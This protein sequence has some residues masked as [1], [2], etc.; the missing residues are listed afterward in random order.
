ME[1]KHIKFSLNNGY[2]KIILHRLDSKA[3]ALN[4]EMIHELYLASQI[5]AKKEVKVV[6]LSSAR[7]MFCAGGDLLEFTSAK[8]KAGL[9]KS[10]TDTLHRA[11][12][13]FSK[14]DAPLVVLLDGMVAGGGMSLALS[15]DYIISTDKTQIL[16][17]YTAS[18][19]SPDASSTYFLAKHVGL[20]RAKELFLTNRILS[21]EEAY[22]WGIINKIVKPEELQMVSANIVNGFLNGATKAFGAV[23]RLLETTFSN[24]LEVQLDMEAKSFVNLINSDDAVEGL[25]LFANKKNN[26]K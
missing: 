11:L 25:H 19:L 17:A 12:L 2:A 20:L 7:N 3:N 24:S 10:N 26:I 4:S 22:D 15:G 8:N 13:N 9:A 14:M 21:A 6:S 23:K 18:G 16:S 1:P 5:C